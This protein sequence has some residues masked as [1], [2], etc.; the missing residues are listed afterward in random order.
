MLTIACVSISHL[1]KE[2]F[3][4]ERCLLVQVQLL[5]DQIRGKCHNWILLFRWNGCPERGGWAWG[6]LSSR[7]EKVGELSLLIK[8]CY[9]VLWSFPQEN[10]R[11]EKEM[12][13]V[14][15]AWRK[16]GSRWSQWRWTSATCIVS[17]YVYLVWYWGNCLT[18]GVDRPSVA[19]PV[20]QTGLI[21]SLSLSWSWCISLLDSA[22]EVW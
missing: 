7:M 11:V 3:R 21:L 14:E 19:S 5:G 20:F 9:D 18:G 12:S 15:D 1:E 6:D 16:R 10:W 17:V 4:K 22:H 13:L 8:Y 2:S